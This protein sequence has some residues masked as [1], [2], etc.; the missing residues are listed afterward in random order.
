[1]DQAFDELP[2]HQEFASSV[3]KT[4]ELQVVRRDSSLGQPLSENEAQQEM[5]TFAHWF[6]NVAEVINIPNLGNIGEALLDESAYLSQVRFD[7]SI[8]AFALEI[9]SVLESDPEVGLNLFAGEATSDLFI[10]TLVVN[11]ILQLNT[12]TNIGSRLKIGLLPQDVFPATEKSLIYILD[13]FIVSG[14][15]LGVHLEDIIQY[16]KQKG[17]EAD[18]IKEMIRIRIMLAEPKI[19]PNPNEKLYNRPVAN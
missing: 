19:Q 14:N 15:Q 5:S 1:M 7:Q 11:R 13:D 4:I 2:H 3:P 18:K 12:S 10:S 9:L 6:K 8:N 17:I 16:F